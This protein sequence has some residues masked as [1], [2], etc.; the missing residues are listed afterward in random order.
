MTI[1][2]IVLAAGESSRFN[3]IK[4]LAAWEKG[5][6]LSQAIE[7][8]ESICGKN[9]VIVTG[10]HAREIVAAAGDIQTIYNEQWQSGLGSSIA[11]GIREASC[12]KADTAILM[13]VDQPFV[14]PDHLRKLVDHA[15]T[16]QS[17]TLSRDDDVTGPP[18]A[19]PAEFFQSLSQLQGDKGL[20]GVLKNY[21][22]VETSGVLRDID[23][24]DD[25]MRLRADLK[26]A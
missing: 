14:T 17:C 8:A 10:G 12:Y 4:A 11:A 9:I 26:T 5:T 15:Q 3:G 22:V 24:Q 1:W 20:K 6:L 25:L 19:I 2:A 18:A 21:T 13:P 23:T 16:H 7:T